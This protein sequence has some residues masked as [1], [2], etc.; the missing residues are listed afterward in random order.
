MN[1]MMILHG[2]YLIHFESPGYVP[3]GG[4]EESLLRERSHT[5]QSM[6]RDIWNFHGVKPTRQSSK[7]N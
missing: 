5:L 4:V 6:H 3:Y 2:R 7:E 1:R